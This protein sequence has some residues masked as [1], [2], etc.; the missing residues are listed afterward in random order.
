MSE[1]PNH[2]RQKTRRVFPNPQ[3][4]T[5]DGIVAMGV[6][7]TVATLVEAYSF[8]IFPWPHEDLPILWFSPDPRGVLDF[9]DLH[10][11]KSLRKF[12]SKME[13]KV[14]FDKA[15]AQ[16]INE[17][18][19]TARPGQAGT[20]ITEPIMSAYR[21]FHKAGYC[22]SV[23]VWHGE[24]LVGGLY[25]VLIG[26]VFAGESMFF[27]KSNASKVALVALVEKLQGMGH[28]WMDIQ[29]LTPVTESLGGK[30]ISKAEYYQRIK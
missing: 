18:A 10:I 1:F 23:E 28:A 21:E 6:P 15:F 11:S 9:A 30:Y 29:M 4:P 14:T 22:H 7:L 16:V 25:G 20:W 5:L 12:M 24:N 13:F 27:K 3:G 19:Q 2:S 8:G 26:G 17:C